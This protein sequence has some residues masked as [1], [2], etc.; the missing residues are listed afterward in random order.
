M[1]NNLFHPTKLDK[2]IEKIGNLLS[3]IFLFI[4]LISLYEIAMRY[5]FNRPT[6]WVHE[7]ASFLGGALFIFGGAYAL[8]TNKHVRVVLLYD[9]VSVRHKHYL[10]IFHHLVGLVFSLLMVWASYLM[11]QDAWF[12]PN[13]EIHLQTSGSAWNPVFPAY[14][15]A[16]ILMTMLILSLQFCLHLI[17]E[18]HALRSKPNA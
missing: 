18:V 11:V 6:I 8:A 9:H 4:V 3:F 10:N 13:G 14:L 15:K 7:T 17:A 12:N 2:L 16:I 1:N 5:A